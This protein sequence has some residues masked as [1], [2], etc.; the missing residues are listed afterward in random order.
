[1]DYKKMATA[2]AAGGAVL[3]AGAAYTMKQKNNKKHPD[4]NFSSGGGRS[5]YLS[6]TSLASLAAAAYLI[7]DYNFDGENIHIF[8]KEEQ[9]GGSCS[10]GVASGAMLN[11]DLWL[12]ERNCQNF[13]EL[14]R[15]IP[16]CNQSDASVKGEIIHHQDLLAGHPLRINRSCTLENK[17]LGKKE[18][19]LLE[20][21]IL[22]PETKLEKIS[23]SDWFGEN[24]GFFS[25]DFWMELRTLFGLKENVSV[26]YL[27]KTL[28]W[29]NEELKQL[30]TMEGWIALPSHPAQSLIA[31]LYSY[32]N[33]Y[34]VHFHKNT[35]IEDVLFSDTYNLRARTLIINDGKRRQEIN[36]KSDD[37]CI[38]TL[39]P[40]EKDA[41]FGSMN[42]SFETVIKKEGLWNHLASH[43][44]ELNVPGQLLEPKDG[45]QGTFIF[46]F[47]E[48]AVLDVL[49]SKSEAKADH[50]SVVCLAD[51]N[52]GIT[53]N[54]SA[55]SF[56]PHH[57]GLMMWG[58]IL[59]PYE[60]G[61]YIRKT[62]DVC[63]GKEVLVEIL[64]HILD[65]EEAEEI[66]KN[67]VDG[68]ICLLPYAYA[69]KLAENESVLTSPKLND[70]NFAV[71]SPYRM[72]KTCGWLEQQIAS[73]HDAILLLMH[74]PQEEKNTKAKMVKQQTLALH[75]LRQRK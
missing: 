64:S 65:K 47:K 55:H 43:R 30:P 63:N 26:T 13:W 3:A 45:A 20:R 48:K 56:L 71:L 37:L 54:V 38:C 68:T 31:P 17:M 60:Q 4:V 69:A 27:R 72:T 16:A 49:F 46:T 8:Q 1:M 57:D 9:I 62:F 35:E 33:G 61:D 44:S 25:S 22:T 34:G 12:N 41:S 2:F 7:R 39:G 21:L 58:T 23:I 14:F 32:L 75:Y 74:A 50:K 42:K 67:C 59:Y 70:S 28:L 6:D 40:Q 5:V 18:R 11:D 66:L 51:S 53:W 52:W 24:T 10:L 36:L 73:A 19:H 29:R 15:S